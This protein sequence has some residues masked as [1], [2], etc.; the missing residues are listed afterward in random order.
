MFRDSKFRPVNSAACFLTAIVPNQMHR[1][2]LTEETQLEERLNTSGWYHLKVFLKYLEFLHFTTCYFSVFKPSGS[3]RL[4][5]LMFCLSLICVVKLCYAIYSALPMKTF[6]S[7]QHFLHF[8]RS[9]H[10][11]NLYIIF[12]YPS[13]S[14]ALQFCV[15]ITLL[16]RSYI[17]IY[18]VYHNFEP[19]ET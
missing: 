12:F 1:L 10:I 13:C 3:R 19:Q 11:G 4:L 8:P 6:I 14:L 15:F 2:W 17:Q 5:T 7:Y 18:D 16:I 9:F